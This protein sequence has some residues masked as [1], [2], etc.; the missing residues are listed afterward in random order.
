MPIEHLFQLERTRDISGVSGTGLVAEGIE[1]DDGAVI[2]RW[3]NTGAITIFKNMGQVRAVHCAGGH[4]KIIIDG[5]GT[6]LTDAEQ[7]NFG[8][9][10]RIR[11]ESGL[12][13][14]RTCN[15][16]QPYWEYFNVKC[17]G[18]FL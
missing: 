7:E 4:T 18:R 15:L 13:I 3:Y 6:A 9:S 8:H 5:R 14:C 1:F 16:S 10:P 2:L 12:M 11:C 17:R